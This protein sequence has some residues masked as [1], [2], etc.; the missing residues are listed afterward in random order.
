MRE[1]WLENLDYVADQYRLST[2]WLAANRE[3]TSWQMMSTF[4]I[5]AQ[6]EI[7]RPYLASMALPCDHLLFMTVVAMAGIYLLIV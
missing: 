6:G 7:S 4:T 1:V 3:Q 5:P 2:Y